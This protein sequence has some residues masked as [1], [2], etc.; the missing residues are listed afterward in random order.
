M[1]RDITLGNFV[2]KFN[3]NTGEI[4]KYVSGNGNLESVLNSKPK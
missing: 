2:V 4:V 3:N 1:T